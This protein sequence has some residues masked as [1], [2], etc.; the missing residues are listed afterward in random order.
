[1]EGDQ[2]EPN[3]ALYTNGTIAAFGGTDAHNGPNQ[4][5]RFRVER[6]ASERDSAGLARRSAPLTR[7]NS[8]DAGSGASSSHARYLELLSDGQ[9][10]DG[11]EVP[12]NVRYGPVRTF[13]KTNG[14]LQH[15]QSNLQVD[16]DD[17]DCLSDV[18]DESCLANSPT[19]LCENPVFQS[20]HAML[21]CDND[22]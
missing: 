17:N 9:I 19:P 1:M 21:P 6:C 15:Y 22:Y 4:S 5:D 8:T 12:R 7:R 11:Y 13:P 18:T 3:S 20:S 2:L 10:Y 16:N 14:L